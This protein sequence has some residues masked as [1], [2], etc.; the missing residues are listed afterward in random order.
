MLAKFGR[1]KVV[2]QRINAVGGVLSGV[3]QGGYRLGYE[4]YGTLLA[5]LAQTTHRSCLLLTC[6]EL[7]SELAVASA[8]FEQDLEEF[9]ADSE[10][11]ESLLKTGLAPLTTNLDLVEHAA[12]TS[13][14]RAIFNL[15]EFITSN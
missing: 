10:A 12:W 13:V 5:R 8:L 6:R 15:H 11:T 14:T 3:L 1:S 2:T 7:V 9:R 4:G